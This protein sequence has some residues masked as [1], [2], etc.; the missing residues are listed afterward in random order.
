[1]GVEVSIDLDDYEITFQFCFSDSEMIPLVQIARHTGPVRFLVQWKQR[2][3]QD[4]RMGE[5]SHS[6]TAAVSRFRGLGVIG[7]HSNGAYPGR[8]P[9]SLVL[10]PSQEM[11]FDRFIGGQ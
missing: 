1:M 7:F 10:S 4:G 9:E 8:E 2:Q 6:I 5:E 3:M 11:A